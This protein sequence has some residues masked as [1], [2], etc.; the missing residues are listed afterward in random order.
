MQN[1]LNASECLFLDDLPAN[2]QTTKKLGMH[3][4][5][6]KD[7]IEDIK[8]FLYQHSCNVETKMD[9]PLSKET[10]KVFCEHDDM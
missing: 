1:G 3:G 2:I 10:K 5:V 8:Y 9:F 6:F 4:I 7:N